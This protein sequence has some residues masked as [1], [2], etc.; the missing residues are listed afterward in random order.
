MFCVSCIYLEFFIIYFC[1]CYFIFPVNKHC[2]LIYSTQLLALDRYI[3]FYGWKKN[4]TRLIGQLGI[5]RFGRIIYTIQ[6]VATT[7]I[8]GRVRFFCWCFI[9]LKW[10]KKPSFFKH[11][12][13]IKCSNSCWYDSHVSNC[14][15]MLK[16][17]NFCYITMMIPV[18]A[19]SV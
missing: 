12:D 2:E 7:V 16:T 17:Y 4:N 3:C 6:N 18:R 1:Q 14:R 5:L 19:C 10:Y 13:Y 15:L 11:H 8:L 9:S